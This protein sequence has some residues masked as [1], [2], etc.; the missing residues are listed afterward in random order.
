MTMSL[1]GFHDNNIVARWLIGI[2]P[3][4]IAINVVDRGSR[5]KTRNR[6]AAMINP[7]DQGNAQR[8]LLAF[9][10][11]ANDLV[12]RPIR[13]TL[14]ANLVING[15]LSAIADLLCLLSEP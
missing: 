11:S 6:Q 10:S 2:P 1:S 3:S 8:L 13:Q 7:V 5:R 14:P 12:C 15:R 9:A 4:A